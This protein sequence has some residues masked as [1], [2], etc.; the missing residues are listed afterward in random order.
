MGGSF[1]RRAAKNAAWRRIPRA[2]PAH[3]MPNCFSSC[4]AVPR[5]CRL[6]GAWRN[7]RRPAIGAC[8][9]GAGTRIAPGIDW[10]AHPSAGQ[11]PAGAFCHR[12]HRSDGPTSVQVGGSRRVESNATAARSWASPRL[13]DHSRCPSPL[14]PVVRFGSCGAAP[15][16]SMQLDSKAIAARLRSVLPSL[17]RG[18]FEACAERLGVS[19]V[20]LRMSIDPNEPHPTLEVVAAV[21][22]QY[23][24][25]PC[26]VMCG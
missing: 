10:R 19:E 17:R 11:A 24:V 9:S 25:D 15:T 7:E 26:W 4:A 14:K 8:D 12:A 2:G 21:V 23:G 13:I 20:A 18:K 3:R 22:Q 6:R 5:S 16:V 1:S